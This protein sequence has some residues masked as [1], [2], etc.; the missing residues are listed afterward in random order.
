MH[1][2]AVQKAGKVDKQVW[3]TIKQAD[4]ST[5][6][7]RGTSNSNILLGA[8]PILKKTKKEAGG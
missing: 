7:Q 5:L 6:G 8:L 4:S 1:S 2:I 3:R